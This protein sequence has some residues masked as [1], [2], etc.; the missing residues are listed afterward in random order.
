MSVTALTADSMIPLDFA[1]PLRFDEV[2][3]LLLDDAELD[4]VDPFADE[5]RP[6]D[7][8]FLLPEDDPDRADLEAVPDFEDVPDPALRDDEPP[9]LPAADRDVELVDLLLDAD[10]PALEPDFA[11]L[12]LLADDPDRDPPAPDP[13]LEAADDLAPV[14]FFVDEP[15][16]DF[17]RA[18]DVVDLDV[19]ADLDFAPDDADPDFEPVEDFD[20]SDLDVDDFDEPAFE[21]ED[22]LVVAMI[23]LRVIE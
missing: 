9:D 8:P 12:P 21:P 7:D 6:E 17:P 3:D 5:L 23:F 1:P 19:V 14:L 18:A 20:P 10:A 16:E 4:F 13:D 15:P 11:A 2:E 22:F